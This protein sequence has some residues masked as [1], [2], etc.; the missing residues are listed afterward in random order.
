MPF[1]TSLSIFFHPVLLSSFSWALHNM[2]S[3]SVFLSS[4]FFPT[5]TLHVTSD[6]QSPSPSFCHSPYLS[7]FVGLDFNL[8]CSFVSPL[9][10]CPSLY[11]SFLSSWYPSEFSTTSLPSFILLLFHTHS[12]KQ[13]DLISHLEI[14]AH[15]LTKMY[16]SRICIHMSLR[17]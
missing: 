17:V 5:S 9:F 13:H 12:H 10:I 3:S 2:F 6:W 1:L 16:H 15:F 11:L 8:H 4:P 7:F 14:W